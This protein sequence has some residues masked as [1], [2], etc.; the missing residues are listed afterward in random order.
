[1][2]IIFA[3]YHK[4]EYEDSTLIAAYFSRQKAELR[5]EQ[6]AKEYEYEKSS[7]SNS[8]Y[9]ST[10]GAFDTLYIEPIAVNDEQ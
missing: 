6:E 2:K 8:L 7:T 1:M 4:A 5:L 3:V 10:Y 9:V